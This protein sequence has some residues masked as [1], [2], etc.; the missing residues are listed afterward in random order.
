MYRFPLPR[1]LTAVAA[2]LASAGTAGPAVATEDPA[3]QRF[4]RVRFTVEASE[5][6][7]ND[8]LVA[9]LSAQREGPDAAP[10]AA[11]VNEI[12]AWAVPLARAR[13]AIEVKTLGYHTTPIY[14]QQRIDGWRVRQAL[15]LRGS[16][17]AAMT[18]LLGELQE[19]LALQSVRYELSPAE[20]ERR[21]ATLIGEAL[22]AYAARARAIADH[23]GRDR[24][25][26][27]SMD[28]G[29]RQ[30]QPPRPVARAA[31]AMSAESRPAPVVEAGARSL[32]VTVTAEIELSAAP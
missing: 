18:A 32:T 5:R 27:V 11:E 23:L 17:A 13:P 29:T 3:A 15:E 8:T 20:L 7:P 21:Q 19:R 9:V 14:R 10:A 2:L 6:V 28:V 16:D 31:A 30:A 25:R 22:A 24:F 26:L 4:D 12:M 1:L